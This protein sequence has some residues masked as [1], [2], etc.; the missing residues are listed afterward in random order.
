MAKAT[1][2]GCQY[3][4][5]TKKEEYRKWYSQTHAP[6]QTKNVYRGLKY[7]P[8]NNEEVAK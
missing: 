5:D 8:C 3:D 4:T 7:R 6:S 1:Y 2:R